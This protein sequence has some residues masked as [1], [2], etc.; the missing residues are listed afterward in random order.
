METPGLSRIPLERPRGSDAMFGGRVTV[1]YDDPPR[2]R[3][4]MCEHQARIGWDAL[5]VLR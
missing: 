2:F 1:R 3:P 5:D 4:P